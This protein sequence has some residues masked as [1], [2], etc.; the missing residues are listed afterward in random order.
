MPCVSITCAT[1]RIGLCAAERILQEGG[2]V[3]IS[4]R[5]QGNVSAALDSLKKKGWNEVIGVR[6]H[7]SMADQR[8]QL[9]DAALERF[10][11]IDVL[12][13]NAAVNPAVGSILNCTEE[14]WQKIF[15]VNVKS[16]FLLAKEVTPILRRQNTGGSIILMSSYAGLC[17]WRVSVA[18]TY[19]QFGCSHFISL[20]WKDNRRIFGK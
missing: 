11:K 10:G 2:K 8:Q 6:C 19:P 7:V 14:K 20:S 13:S 16:T 15:D 1:Y 5:K 3:V 9:F 17:P 4:S 12:V 18:E